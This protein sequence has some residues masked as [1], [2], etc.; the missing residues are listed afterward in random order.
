MLTSLTTTL[1]GQ[2]TELFLK[3]LTFP[4]PEVHSGTLPSNMNSIHFACVTTQLTPPTGRWEYWFCH[5]L[6][7]GARDWLED[8]KATI[9]TWRSLSPPRGVCASVVFCLLLLLI[10]TTFWLSLYTDL[11]HTYL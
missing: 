7:S 11:H 3:I 2:V 6:C 9:P 8:I 1:N 4:S 5:C 10:H